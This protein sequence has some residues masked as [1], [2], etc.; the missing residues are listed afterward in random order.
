MANVHTLA[1]LEEGNSTSS[2]RPNAA[3][4]PNPWASTP[5]YS[6]ATGQRV[7]ATPTEAEAGDDDDDRSAMT[8]GFPNVVQMPGIDGRDTQFTLPQSTWQRG[9]VL[10]CGAC[11]PCFIPPLWSAG[12]KQQYLNLAQ[13]FTFVVSLIQVIMFIVELSMGGVVS[14]EDNP[15]FGP[16]GSTLV[17]LG[18]K[19]PYL[20]R[21]DCE[22]WR[23][24]T[25]IFLHAGFLHI[26]FNL[27]FQLR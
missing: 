24:I 12:R 19:D 25:P 18:A 7:A 20:M 4:L 9:A 3:P 14:P 27:L 10:C 13:S 16:S 8:S 6:L 5:G 23:F 15:S 26:L 1:D 22:I 17:K 11:F 21:H 2:Q